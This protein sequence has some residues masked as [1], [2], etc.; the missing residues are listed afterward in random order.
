[1][2]TSQMELL[3]NL[4][5]QTMTG[6]LL[7]AVKALQEGKVILL[8]DS[9]DRENEGDLIVAAEK[10]TPSTMNFLIKEGS[11]VVCVA[12][13]KE[14][15][16]FLGLPLMSSDNTNFFQTAFTL[17]I[18]ARF[19]VT[20][21]VSAKD[22]AHTILTAMADDAKASDLARPGHVFPLA[23]RKNG[24]FERMGHTEGSVDLMRIA[25]LKPG[26]VLCELMNKDGSMTVG[27]D[28][29]AFAKKHD[30][31][32][33]TVEDILLHRIKTEDVLEQVTK[34]V[35]T[36]FGDMTWHHFRFLDSVSVD[37]FHQST[38]KA[39][40]HTATKITFAHGDNLRNRFFAQVLENSS[41]DPLIVALQS[42]QAKNADLAIM[43]TCTASIGKTSS[44]EALKKNA[45]ICRALKDLLINHAAVPYNDVSFRIAADNFSITIA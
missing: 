5:L 27:D 43:T 30:I 36:R 16:D 11:G 38:W 12:M 35:S 19:G 31:P 26:A 3:T 10:I 22:R 6:Q 14:R 34:N 29:I 1:M 7:R 24:V 25:S 15:L 45:I 17:S 2:T 39:Q 4:S 23:A 9:N 33:V 37:I 13:P 42:L 41:D 32:V 18:E 21:G 20:T 40:E 28:R 44:E 8:L